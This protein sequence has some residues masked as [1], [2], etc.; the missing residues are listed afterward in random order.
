MPTVSICLPVYNG[1]RYLGKSI[2]SVLNQTFADFELLISNDC[3][4]DGSWEIVQNFAKQDERINAWTN[5]IDW[6]IIP[7]TMRVSQKPLANTSN[8]LL[9][10]I[11]LSSIFG[12]LRLRFQK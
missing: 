9:R 5:G 3:S 8:F 4:K 7:T 11:F 2:E 1:A 6:A 10:M 12:A